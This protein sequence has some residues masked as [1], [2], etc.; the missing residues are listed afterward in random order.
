VR[1]S[2]IHALL[3]IAFTAACGHSRG[4]VDENA[5]APKRVKCAG[6]E[7]AM[8]KDTIGIRGTVAPLLDRDVQI[9]PQIAGRLLAIDVHEGDRVIKEQVIARVDDAALI[10]VAQQ[11]DA[12]VS[13][14]RAEYQNAQTTLE[15]V[16]RVFEHGIVP[17]QEVDDAAAREVAAHAAQAESEAAAHQAHRQIERTT[18]RSPLAGVVLKLFKKP[19][20]LVD[21]TAATAVAEVADTSELELV[22][23]VP[24]QD[25]VQLA[26]GAPASI[27]FPALPGRMFSGAVARVA[28][29]VER[30]TGVGAV[31]VDIAHSEV[32]PPIGIFGTA[33]IESG[34][35]R[36][37]M[38]VAKAALRAFNGDEAEVV[39][40]GGDHKAHVRKVRGGAV[41]DDK[42]AISGELAPN[43]R[44]AI[45]PVLGLAEGDA[46]EAAP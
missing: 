15:R 44:V 6:V 9:A 7:S 35:P 2:R 23:D 22:A 43:E 45:E 5:P 33:E 13:R 21:G 28:P 17:K 3:C 32:T 19:G 1:N 41:D 26:L 12:A 27:A 4:D 16:R 20:E 38:L 29:T 10:D 24:A 14:A 36:P 46:L 42:V 11:A 25:L 31:R 30:T 37:V 40:C 34:A 8:R 39:V 18:V